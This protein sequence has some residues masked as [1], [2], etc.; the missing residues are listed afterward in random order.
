MKALDTTIEQVIDKS[1]LIRR[2]TTPESDGGDGVISGD[3][4]ELNSQ[5]SPDSDVNQHRSIKSVIVRIKFYSALLSS[6]ERPSEVLFQT[7]LLSRSLC[8]Y[9][10]SFLVKSY[11]LLFILCLF[12]VTISFRFTV[13]VQF[14]HCTALGLYT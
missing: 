1:N 4:G 5:R 10:I 7:R 11:P 14:M 6:L 3:D 13:N 9:S 8:M 12:L 2:R